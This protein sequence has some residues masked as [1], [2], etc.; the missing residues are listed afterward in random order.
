MTMAMKRSEQRIE[1]ALQGAQEER[2]KELQQGFDTT[3]AELYEGQVSSG[4]YPH[5]PVPT[6]PSNVESLRLSDPGLY[7]S[8]SDTLAAFREDMLSPEIEFEIFEAMSPGT[9]RAVVS[10]IAGLDASVLMTFKQ[11]LTFVETVLR[12]VVKPDGTKA[13]A[14]DDLGVSVKDAMNMS[15]KVTQVLTRDL[16]KIYTLERV[17]KQERA[18]QLVMQRHMDREQQSFFLQALEE[19][20][21]E[22]DSEH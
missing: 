1:E 10:Q 16:P 20:E 11:M 18:F 14:G 2:Q 7:R 5:L 13:V 4:R 17:Q 8:V 15:I 3:A 22:L 12:R 6:K 19:I 21:K 9:Q